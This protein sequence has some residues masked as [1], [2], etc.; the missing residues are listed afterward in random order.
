MGC[1]L[2][3]GVILV[4]RPLAFG[5]TGTPSP[6]TPLP[7]AGAGNPIGLL[8]RV[9]KLR[10]VQLDPFEHRFLARDHAATGH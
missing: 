3:E 8:L 2:G 6:L 7:Q 5:L 9:K 1:K 10:A 4:N